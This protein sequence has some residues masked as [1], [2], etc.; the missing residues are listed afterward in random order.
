[1][2]R[3]SDIVYSARVVLGVALACVAAAAFGA[4]Q[5]KQVPEPDT[6]VRDLGGQ[7]ATR[8]C[9]TGAKWLRIGFQSLKL[10]GGDRLVL[11]SSSGDRLELKGSRWNDRTFYTRA[12]EGS[13]VDFDTQFD[14]SSSAYKL[15]GYQ[16][17]VKP[18]EDVSYVV[19]GA[20]DLCDSTP[21]DCGK[22]SDLILAM[23]PTAALT[24]GDN[25]YTNA[26]LQ[27]YVTRY[28]PYWGR[29]KAIT[30]PTPGNH[31]YYTTNAAG[32]F[33]Y[34]NGVGVDTGPAGT[35]GE[36][37]YS[38][39]V[40]EW[41][42][43]ALNSKSGSTVSTTQLAWLDADLRANTKP[44]T[45]AFMHYPYVSSGRYTIFSTMKPIVDRLYASR[46]DLLLTGHDH[47]YQ[48]FMP[49][50]GEKVAQEDGVRQVIT[51]SGGGDKY[52]VLGTH[53]LFQAGQGHSFGVLRLD[54]TAT[55][56][57][58]AFVPVVGKTWTDSFS[59]ECHRAT[60]VVPD[61][62][63]TGTASIS[64]PRSSSGGK[65]VT[66]ASYGAF[67]APVQFTISGLPSGVTATWSIN[68]LTGVPDAN[69][70]SRVTL[71]VSSSASIGTYP[72]TV[73]GTSAP[74]ARTYKFNLLVK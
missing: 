70:T 9:R 72:L 52:T 46:A 62:L 74:F 39:D 69:T 23:N 57:D 54:L 21:A 17:G 41:H 4:Q 56:Y 27:E 71:R 55:G 5:V 11:T 45:A 32:Y 2:N 67:A 12:L 63:L 29:F 50:D 49:M 8:V 51:G 68:P 22:T 24:F 66:L 10:Q 33:D 64:I 34:Y 53:P 35:R 65:V 30:F 60:G 18:L 58:G 61:Y 36:G 31:E 43:I 25:A 20:G 3:P 40:G 1:V 16:A 13:C 47:N 6:I 42:F 28:D 38:F 59:G 73:T 26:T 44:C 19:G 37:W 48:R 14:D 7:T 15:S